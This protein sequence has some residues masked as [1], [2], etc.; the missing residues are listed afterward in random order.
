[1]RSASPGSPSIFSLSATFFG[2]TRPQAPMTS[3]NHPIGPNRRYAMQRAELAPLKAAG[4]AA[5]GTVNDDNKVVGYGDVLTTEQ[6]NE[7]F[8]GWCPK[9][10]AQGFVLYKLYTYAAAVTP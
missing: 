5:G 3:L 7:L 8:E 4:K 2:R 9:R 10:Y 1:M 6:A